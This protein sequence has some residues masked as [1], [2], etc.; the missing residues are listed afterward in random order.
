[1]IDAGSYRCLPVVKTAAAVFAG[2]ALAASGA[3]R[4]ATPALPLAEPGAVLAALQ[5]A[6][7]ARDADAYLRLWRLP[8]AR[9][10]EAE[11]AFLL[12]SW[13][14]DEAVLTVEAPLAAAGTPG[15][16]TAWRLTYK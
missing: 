9:A 5:A 10:E 3:A 13:R 1:M 2:V 12:E 6:F 8:D 4:E 14:G 11:R 16:L 7:S 15:R